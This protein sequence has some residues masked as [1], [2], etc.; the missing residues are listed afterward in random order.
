MK[1]LRRRPVYAWG[2]A[3]LCVCLAFS[4][5]NLKANWEGMSKLQTQT[6]INTQQA[7]EL[8]ASQQATDKQAAIAEDRY[9][10]GCLF[11]VTSRS[12]QQTALTA[13]EPV[14]DKARN[15]P[16]QPGAI[17]CDVFGTT[18]KIVPSENGPV[19]S[20]IA[21]TGDSSVVDAA[22]AKRNRSKSANLPPRQ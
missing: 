8:K 15:T 12:N 13:G 6:R 17:V 4:Y 19:V 14:M 20:E 9:N 22:Y 10:K 16:L 5:P 18:G 21:F 1:F 3:G 11:V 2:F 7:W